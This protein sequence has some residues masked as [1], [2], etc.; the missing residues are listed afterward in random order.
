MESIQDSG[1]VGEFVVDGVLVAVERVQGGDLDPSLERRA[2]LVEPCLVHGPGAAGY[3]VE[4]PGSDASVLV[5]GQVDHAGEFLRA[6]LAGTHVVP[7][8]FVH[9]EGG[10]AGEPGLVVGQRR[11]DGLDR[12]PHR[13]PRHPQLTRQPVDGG[14]LTADLLEHPPARP[15]GQQPARAGYLLVLLGEHPGRARRLQ[16]PP[17]A[18]APPQPGRP[19]ETRDVDQG[20]RAPAVALG[21]HPTRRAAHHRRRGLHRDHEHAMAGLVDVDHVQ[22]VQADQQVAMVTV[23]RGRGSA[24]APRRLGH[25]EAFRSG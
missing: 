2:A 14:V 4:Q 18:L 12:A 3:E 24:A 22:A 19:R 13:L 11:Q 8:V 15:G 20:R 5:T 9:P 16:A 7:Q 6:A 25:V 21:D 1:G 23:R 10:H 17:R